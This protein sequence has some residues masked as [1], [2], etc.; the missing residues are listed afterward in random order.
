MRLFTVL[1]LV[2]VAAAQQ[3]TQDV[4]VNQDCL[5]TEW[6][7]FQACSVTCGKG[8]ELRKREISVHPSGTGAKCPVLQAGWELGVRCGV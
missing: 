1:A 3:A 4:N 6:G 7:Q 2:A 8:Q 5:V